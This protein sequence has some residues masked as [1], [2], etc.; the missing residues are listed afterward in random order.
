MLIK[1]RKIT[2]PLAILLLGLGLG[3]AACGDDDASDEASE[4]IE[5]TGE[6]V[7]EAGEEAGV[8]QKRLFPET[9][10][11]TV[12]HFKTG[13]LFQCPWAV[14]AAIEKPLPSGAVRVKNA[15]YRIGIA[16]QI[17][18]DMVDLAGDVR[19]RRHN[20]VASVIAWGNDEKLKHLLSEMAASESPELYLEAFVEPFRKAYQFAVDHLRE[21]LRRLF[22]ENHQVFVEPSATFIAARI[23]ADRVVDPS[24]R[25]DA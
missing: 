10:L 2:S 1:D 7:E 6:A 4:A 19:N 5:E 20:Y 15:L 22:H 12:H 16:C 13:L 3:L 9:V 23:G 11:S 25:G 14:P 18:D 8:A 24:G 17:F 21:A